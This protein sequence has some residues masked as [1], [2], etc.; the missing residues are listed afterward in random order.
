V[1]YFDNFR[2]PTVV[3]ASE[4]DPADGATDVDRDVVF[5][6]TSGVV[7]ATHDVFFGPDMDEVA[8]AAKD[9]LA[10]YPSVTYQSVDVTSYEPP[11][12]ELG[13]TYY[14]R[15]DEVNEP[16]IWAGDVWSFTVGEYVTVDDFEDYKGDEVPVTEQIWGKWR[17]GI[18]YGTEATPPY[19]AG[20]GTGSE[21]GDVDTLSYTEETIVNNGA[22]SMPYWYNN[23][24]ADKAKYSEA[25]MTL[26][27]VRDWTDQ[28]VRALYLYFRGYPGDLG[29]L[30]EAPV[31][32]Y[33][34]TAAGF[35]I[36][37]TSDEF[38]YAWKMLDSVGSITAKVSAITNLTEDKSLNEWA[39]AGL[40][41]R[42]TL[43]PDSKH[44]FVCITGA[45]G[46]SLQYRSETAGDSVNHEQFPDVSQ[47][48]HWVKLERDISGNVTAYHA[49]DVSGSPGAWQML[50]V[51][52][53]PMSKV[54]YIGLALT[55]HQDYTQA[56]AVFSD[57]STTGD[58]TG[59]GWTDQDIGIPKNEAE[60]MYV[61]VANS[62]GTTG[63]V[64]HENPNAALISEWT[65]WPIALKDFEDQGVDLTDVN[66]IA[67][68][69]GD[70]D[71][72][73]A[74][75]SGKMYFDDIRLYRGTCILSER[76][77]AFAGVDYAPAGDP[78]GDCVVNYQ[79]LEIMLA[80]WL[81]ADDILVAQ[82]P[83]T[84]G[85][86]G[87]YPV[88]EGSGTTTADASGQGHQGTLNGDV[89][90]VDG[91]S[92]FGKA[93]EFPGAGGNYV[94]SG[95]WDPSQG[96]G[97][98]TVAAWMKWA[99]LTGGYQGV[100]A[101]RDEWSDA[102]TMWQIELNN[103]TGSIGFSRYDSYTDFGTNIPPVGD[104]QHVAVTFDGTT[105]EMYIDGKSVGTSTDF[106][107]G[108]KTD[109]HVVFG[110]VDQ[111]GGNPFNGTIDEVYLY[112]R[113]LSSAEV[114]YLADDTPGDG[115]DYVPLWSVANLY[116][117]EPAGSKAVDF[118]DFA[119]L[120]D[121]W[122]D[123]SFWP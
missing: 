15:I 60:P 13:Q 4:P 118:K 88:N 53:V 52:A 56:Q 45:Q 117:Q 14:W 55:S 76:S 51:V 89:D 119:V 70:R 63:V 90:W 100:V 87:H 116:D 6:W 22:Q 62:N 37:D 72:P 74:G 34:M 73:Q 54:A 21:I 66:S 19:Y 68:G 5:G 115:L 61:V 17:D 77:A 120:A 18:G 64:Y 40:M 83:G 109:A 28:D 84:A 96:T 1:Y 123:E 71:N 113:A 57:I 102:D 111:N 98:L 32:T 106:S 31:G 79:E 10:S 92:G 26:S 91:M 36:W 2:I 49:D 97:Q 43:A 122:L 78:A 46:V 59:A 103:E 107:F 42:E 29:G 25:Q 65:Q 44:A 75:G 101:K 39:K 80:D 85:L 58:V 16:D 105:C 114:A 94:D 104:W 38:H 33:T 9:D 67:I 48:P 23:N 86:V 121:S 35:D 81:M 112:N 24:K 95:T 69:F 27:S 3:K 12:L 30:T 47:R 8:N 20:N 41:I 7:A 82:E 110:A 50:S 99:G 108:P 93:L 11:T